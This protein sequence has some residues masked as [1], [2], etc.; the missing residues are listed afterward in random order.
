MLIAMDRTIRTFRWEKGIRTLAALV[1]FWQNVLDAEMP[2][3][4]V[5][6]LSSA[7]DLVAWYMARA[8]G[9]LYLCPQHSR[10]WGD[11]LA[12]TD[13]DGHWNHLAEAYALAK[14]QG[15]S[16]EDRHAAEAFLDDFLARKPSPSYMKYVAR[17]MPV[18]RTLRRISRLPG[19]L[20]SFGRDRRFAVDYH[21]SFFRKTEADLLSAVRKCSMRMGCARF[22]TA[23]EPGEPFFL[24][25]LHFQPESTTLV[26]AP[27][28]E[29]LLG[30]AENIAKSLPSG[31]RLYV[32]EH[33]PMLG[34]RPFW[35]YREL[36]RVPSIRLLRPEVDTH[37]LIAASAGVVTITNTTGIEA[38]LHGKNVAVLGSIFYDVFDCVQKV[39][40]YC[41]LP[42][43]LSLA[44]TQPGPSRE[45][46]VRI[47]HSLLHSTHV[48]NMDDP[49]ENPQT[50]SPQNVEG[51]ADALEAE[52]RGPSSPDAGTARGAGGTTRER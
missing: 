2:S 14:E 21:T 28:C 3:A 4:I 25:P 46:Q 37:H 43:A 35:F 16:A 10:L 44:A 41:S 30:V 6:E 27:F 32:K 5:G 51:I 39:D 12:F 20:T 38:I 52:I 22:F 49:K 24:F 18:R 47:V 13:V 29:N 17:R 11:R 8:R 33:L 23:P 7:P 34:R 40:S 19:K 15:V 1:L 31:H 50:S 45:E 26:L 48:G 42:R 36:L 9:I